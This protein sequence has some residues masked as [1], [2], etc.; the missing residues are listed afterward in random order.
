MAML[1]FGFVHS[2]SHANS[3]DADGPRLYLFARVLFSGLTPL[4][5]NVKP[6]KRLNLPHND[7]RR[8]WFC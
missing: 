7:F 1:N 3:R 2:V 4:P 5:G 6:P 8:L